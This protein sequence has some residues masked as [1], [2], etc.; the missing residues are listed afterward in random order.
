MKR[1]PLWMAATLLVAVAWTPAA[2]AVC[3]LPGGNRVPPLPGADKCT[4]VVGVQVIDTDGDDYGNGCDA[5]Y[6]QNCLTN[7]IDFGIFRANFE[8]PIPPGVPETDHN[9]DLVV[10][11]P[12]FLI[13]SVLFGKPPD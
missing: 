12:D 10:T 2:S 4:T 6:D 3:M 13:F 9:G 1:F 11:I 7:M 5:D 8:L